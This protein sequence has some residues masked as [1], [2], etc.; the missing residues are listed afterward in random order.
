M[1]FNNS[2][3][4]Y[5][6]RISNDCIL[7]DNKFVKIYNFL[8]VN[9]YRFVSDVLDSKIII[10]DLCWVNKWFIFQTYKKIN[11]YIEKNKSIVLVWC[12]SDEIKEKYWDS[13]VY[14]DSKTHRD[15]EKYFDFKMWLSR[16]DSYNFKNKITI[17]DTDNE[18]KNYWDFLKWSEKKAFVE[19]SNWCQFKC[20][21]C[22]IK[23]IKWDTNSNSI[24]V[25]IEE[26]KVELEKW[27]KEVYL[28]SDDCGSYGLDIWITFPDLLDAI[29]ELD[30]DIKIYITN[31][32]PSL[33][34][35]YYPRI[36]K[37]IYSNKISYI[38]LPIQHTSDRIL[39]LMNRGYDIEKIKE[40]LKD[41]K[42]NSNVELCN[43]IIF[44]YHKETLNE[45]AGTFKLLPYYEK[46][47]Y[48]K[49]SD[50]NKVYKNNSE[51]LEIREKIIL[52]KKLQNKYNIDIAL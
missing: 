39:R 43:H 37:Y 17:L 30:D 48:F 21:Y 31:I 41:M 35:K 49:Y 15:V 28:L 20:T 50:I 29:F 10:L 12:I 38:I 36:K 5:L 16:V 44:D 27:K 14:I 33:W 26:I 47:F 6:D 2:Q 42:L 25:I 9:N 19:I 52:L 46:T 40:V 4:I 45:F 51:N 23:K 22:N 7:S 11:E 1:N 32:Y 13:I 18:F 24:S 3:N 8:L 34:V